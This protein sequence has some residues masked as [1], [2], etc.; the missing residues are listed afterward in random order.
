MLQE[1]EESKAVPAWMIAMES[2]EGGTE[3]MVGEME[4]VQNIVNKHISMCSNIALTIVG[5]AFASPQNNLVTSETVSS[6]L[7][8]IFIALTKRPD[9]RRANNSIDKGEEHCISNH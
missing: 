9:S 3:T 4:T 8:A 6:L 5:Y 2:V 1:K 7:S